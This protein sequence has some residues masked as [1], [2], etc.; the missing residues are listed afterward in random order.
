[1]GFDQTLGLNEFYMNLSGSDLKLIRI[2]KILK[3]NRSHC[4]H[5]SLVAG[6]NPGWAL[7]SNSNEANWGF[8]AREWHTVV[9]VVNPVSGGVAR[10][11]T[12]RGGSRHRG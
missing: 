2:E 10:W 12:G 4:S 6:P 3:N 7:G 5:G 1:M 8:D 9:V 11:G